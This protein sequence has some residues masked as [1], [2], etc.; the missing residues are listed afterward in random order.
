M[1]RYLALVALF[2]LLFLVRPAHAG[3]CGDDICGSGEN[4]TSCPWDCG[5]CSGGSGGSVI[6]TAPAARTLSIWD[7]AYGHIDCPLT[8]SSHTVSGGY[9]TS[10]RFRIL[11]PSLSSTGPFRLVLS[12]ALSWFV[13]K[14]ITFPLKPDGYTSGGWPYW[15]VPPLGPNESTEMSFTVNGSVGLINMIDVQAQPLTRWTGD[16][17]Y[18]IPKSGAELGQNISGFLGLLNQSQNVTVYFESGSLVLAH[19]ERNGSFAVFS[20]NGSNVT[21]VPDRNVI[22]GLVSQY[23]AA[24]SPP[25]TT[26]ISKPYK[27][28][29][30]SKAMKAAPEKS[31]MVITGMDRHE[32]V[33]RPSCRYAC[34]SV[35]A[36]W[37]VGQIGWPFIDSLLAYRISVDNANS[38]LD[39]TINSSYDFSQSPS[40][41]AAAN[42]LFDMKALDR[43]ETA[44][45][46]QPIFTTYNF[47]P[48]PEYALPQMIDARRQLLDYIGENCVQAEEGRIIGESASM[49]PNL[50]LPPPKPP[51]NV[52]VNINAS[53]CGNVTLNASANASMCGNAT[54]NATAANQSALNATVN[55]TVNATGNATGNVTANI[56]ASANNGTAVG[57]NASAANVTITIPLPG[58]LARLNEY[59]PAPAALLSVFLASA[60]LSQNRRKKEPAGPP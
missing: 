2:A 21:A 19:L 6:G 49:A 35:P 39:R 38:A 28:L 60:I 16:C 37:Y 55:G 22:S 15:D 29:N 14:N 11:N 54:V 48:P 59:C 42:A 32:C 31:C 12:S 8:S 3:Y 24:A 26:D 27:T 40:Y 57:Q 44:V 50:I 23:A 47:C 52:S 36:C 58:A 33:D 4:C 43:Y 5:F 56:N 25:P 18:F 17:A 45:I 10:V 53:A 13:P 41:P 51:P 46:Y 9:N 34:A 7:G 30:L 1:K 20:F